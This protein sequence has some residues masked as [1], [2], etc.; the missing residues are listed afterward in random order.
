MIT[1]QPERFIA[2]E[3]IR[4]KIINATRDEIPFSIAVVIEEMTPR[5]G[6]EII[7][8]R[9]EIY[10]ER[11]SQTGIVIGKGGSLLKEAGSAA[12]VDLQLLLGQQVNLDLWVKV[13]RDWRNR[14]GSLHEFGYS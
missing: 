6:K 14:E 11:P 9:A 2:A 4:E 8:I 3:I 12:R 5:Q 13:K 10:V 7:D 1:D